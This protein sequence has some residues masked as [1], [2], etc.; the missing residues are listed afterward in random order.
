MNRKVQ[1]YD[2]G[3]SGSDGKSRLKPTITN[4]AYAFDEEYDIKKGPVV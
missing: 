3:P 1:S 2:G 4:S